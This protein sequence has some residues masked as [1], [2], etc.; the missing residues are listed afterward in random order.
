MK[1]FQ[2]ETTTIAK[3]FKFI[4]E[5]RGSKLVLVSVHPHTQICFNYRLKNGDKR[6][7][8]IVSAEFI[9][10]KGWKA[11]GNKLT[12]YS[13]LSGFKFLELDMEP[14]SEATNESPSPTEKETEQPPE[15]KKPAPKPKPPQSSAVVDVPIP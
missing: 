13:R 3:P 1:R 15:E 11:N 6:S 7:K 5:E 2:I 14:S 8:E 9:D 10:V 12:G 4:S